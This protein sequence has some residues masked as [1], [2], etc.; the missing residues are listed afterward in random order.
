M[1]VSNERYRISAVVRALKV[2]KLFDA[3]HKEMSL[4]ELSTMAGITKSSMIRVLS[5]LEEEGFIR[6]CEQTKKYKL[7]ITIFRL[8]N[9]AFGFLNVRDEAKDILK[10]V[11]IQANA[12][13]H[14]AVMEDQKI[15]IIDRIWP[16]EQLDTMALT[17]QIGGEV[18]V[19][20]TGTGKVLLAYINEE[21][22]KNI[23]EHCDFHAYSEHTITNKEKLMEEIVKIR[24]QGYAINNGEHEPYLRCVT[25]PIFGYEHK[26]EASVSITGLI[27]VMNEEKIEQS[28]QLLMKATREISKRLGCE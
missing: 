11:A 21:S 10:E 1:S 28:K 12:V 9:T 24:Q 25:F 20:C 7:G 8:S 27:Q 6:Y 16:N 22:R 3:Q 17:S 15:V 13:V 23:L 5:S 4:T 14:L 18:P 2:L 19:H 26:I